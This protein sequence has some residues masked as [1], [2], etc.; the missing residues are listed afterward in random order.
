MQPSL[1]FLIAPSSP[2]SHSPV[3]VECDTNIQNI[4]HSVVSL[5]QLRSTKSSPPRTLALYSIHF[6]TEA[7][8]FNKNTLFCG[9]FLN[10]DSAQPLPPN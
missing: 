2:L 6:Q 5:R 3:D 4:S 1:Q 9:I 8:I 10:E 7:F